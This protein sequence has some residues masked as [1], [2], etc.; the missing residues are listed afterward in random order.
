MPSPVARR[1]AIL[2]A[3]QPRRGAA[4]RRADGRNPESQ[5][6]AKEQSL[7]RS[8]CARS[9]KNLAN[10]LSGPIWIGKPSVQFWS[11]NRD[12]PDQTK[13]SNRANRRQMPVH[14]RYSPM[15]GTRPPAD[16]GRPPVP[17][18]ALPFSALH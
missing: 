13:L 9:P 3:N 4:N 12:P 8:D 15:E 16:G 7:S 11:R 2:P 10:S 18:P 1:Q 14:R 17:P 5:R 6:G